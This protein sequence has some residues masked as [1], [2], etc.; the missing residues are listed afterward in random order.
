MPSW[1]MFKRVPFSYF[2]SV[3]ASGSWFVQRM[4]LPALAEAVPAER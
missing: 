3:G 4:A 2:L 1:N